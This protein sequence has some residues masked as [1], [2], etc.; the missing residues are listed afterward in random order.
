MRQQVGPTVRARI[1]LTSTQ[2]RRQCRLSMQT[3][4]CRIALSAG[5]LRTIEAP[6]LGRRAAGGELS[7]ELRYA[8]TD[9]GIEAGYEQKLDEQKDKQS[10]CG[11]RERDM[12][13][14]DEKDS[15]AGAPSLFVVSSLAPVWDDVAEAR[16]LNSH[17]VIGFCL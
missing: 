12:T 16:S 6:R 7:A 9:H 1:M 8:A 10:A 2:R 3:T 14:G 17:D 13:H 15:L 5:C 4:R 11:M